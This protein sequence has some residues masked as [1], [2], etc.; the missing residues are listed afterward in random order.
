MITFLIHNISEKLF[1]QI[2]RLV[3]KQNRKTQVKVLSSIR[4]RRFVPPKN[5]PSSL[6]LLREDRNRWLILSL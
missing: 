1:R 6:E 3:R 2:Q 4:Q 5:S